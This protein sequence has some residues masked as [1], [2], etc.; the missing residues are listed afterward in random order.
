MSTPSLVWS[1]QGTAAFRFTTVRELEESAV[2]FNSVFVTHSCMP[3]ESRYFSLNRCPC[4]IWYFPT[5]DA[6]ARASFQLVSCP[7]VVFLHRHNPQH[8]RF[9]H[10]EE[11][12]NA[13]PVAGDPGV[14]HQ[15][16]SSCSCAQG[17]HSNGHAEA[18]PGACRVDLWISC[19]RFGVGAVEACRVTVESPGDNWGVLFTMLLMNG[20]L[21]MFF[22]YNNV[23]TMEL[24][25]G[26]P[27]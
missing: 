9:H 23:D 24:C 7:W 10:D 8:L 14:C 25:L 20:M 21:Y 15:A 13:G 26:G 5:Y 3:S 6:Q 22:S 18:V 27:C 19:N 16:V 2:S 17:H 1:A 4:A 11:L 12:S